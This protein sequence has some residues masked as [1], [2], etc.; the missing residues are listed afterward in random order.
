MPIAIATPFC[1]DNDNTVLTISPLAVLIT[2]FEVK[3]SYIKFVTL[4][5]FIA[6][7]APVNPPPFIA[8][9]LAIL[10]IAGYVLFSAIPCLP[11]EYASAMFEF[12]TAPPIARIAPLNPPPFLAIAFTAFSKSGSRASNVRPCLPSV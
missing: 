10:C 12:F 9:A 6:F 2:T 5:I 7:I 11:Q 4:L 1:A 8:I 3:E